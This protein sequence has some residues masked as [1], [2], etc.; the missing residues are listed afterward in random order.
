MK[1]ILIAT[2]TTLLTGGLSCYGATL[3]QNVNLDFDP[4]YIT[5]PVAAYAFGNPTDVNGD[6]MTDILVNEATL[7]PGSAGDQITSLS[8]L[9]FNAN[10]AVPDTR[11]L[12]YVWA[13][14][15]TSGNP[16]TLLGQ[17][18]I[19]QPYINGPGESYLTYNVTTPLIVPADGIL[20]LGAALD[21]DNG[22]SSVTN[23]QLVNMG[24]ETYAPA[25]FGTDALDAS[26]ISAGTSLTD[27]SLNPL[28]STYQ[29]DF[30]WVV[31]GDAVPTPEPSTF[32]MML[33]GVTVGALVWMRS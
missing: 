2:V 30:G 28:A 5:Q 11:F 31:T 12:I 20:W 15:G 33:L 3:Y 26:Y 22:A 9:L 18:V 10:S 21:N 4:L 32:R 6:T 14:D 8:F 16:G 29:G 7:A 27:P 17:F 25:S 23:T 1:P 13:A 24:G 19:A